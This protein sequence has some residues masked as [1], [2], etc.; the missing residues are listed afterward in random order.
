MPRLRP[1]AALAALVLAA[2][3]GLA[4]PPTPQAADLIVQGAR[5]HTSDPAKPEAQAL[6]VRGDRIVYVGSDAGSRAWRGRA[7]QVLDLHGARVLPGLVDAHIHPIDIVPVD[8]CDLQSKAMS[9][10]E[11]TA[12]VHACAA[13][14]KL[15]PG[16]WLD[17]AQWNFSNGNQPDADHPSLRAALDA[18]APG[19]AV[20]L[21]GNDGHHGAFSSAALQ[22]AKTRAGETVGL[23]RA[24]LAGPLAPYRALVGVD[25]A[26]EPNG[27]VNEE[28]RALM[29]AAD[30]LV[31]ALPEVMKAPERVMQ[32]LSASGITAIQDAYVTPQM[33]AFYD[34]L[35]A[36]GALTV[37]ANLAQFYD[38]DVILKADG[39]PDYD[40]M[41]AQAVAIRDHFKGHPLIRADAV[42]LFADGVMEGDPYATPPTPPESPSLKPYLA[43]IFGR[44]AKG[45]PRVTGYV[46][47]EAP[48][49]RAVRERGEVDRGCRRHGRLRQGERLPPRPVHARPAGGCSTRGR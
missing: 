4:A 27:T 22:R 13:R 10:N 28:A 14:Y 45:L 2:Q 21:E 34:A 7:T 35:E 33:V 12:F 18:A 30:P 1:A 11:L 46:D 37:R 6:A 32:V 5:I 24:S 16:G 9:L 48:A 47:Q 36:K 3:P 43:P 41:V 20:Q 8:G 15:S 29:G 26:G 40:G 44:D 17:V 25:A 42:K 31:S 38:P 23:S 49:C 39:S 19:I